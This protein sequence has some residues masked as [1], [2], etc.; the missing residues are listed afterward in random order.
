M[1]RIYLILSLVAFFT[2][3]VSFAQTLEQKGTELIFE[4]SIWFDQAINYEIK[5]RYSDDN[6]IGT[7]NVA[8]CED[9]KNDYID[10]WLNPNMIIVAKPGQVS[11]T[12]NVV[13][14]YGEGDNARYVAPK[15][16]IHDRYAFYSTFKFEA[17][18]A[19]Y[20][21]PCI[22]EYS[23]LCLPFSF[24]MEELITPGDDNMQLE[25]LSET[26]DDVLYLKRIVDLQTKTST[27]NHHHVPA[28]SPLFVHLHDF[29]PAD[30]HA[31]DEEIVEKNRM[32]IHTKGAI[33]V[34]YEEEKEF[35]DVAYL[36]EGHL[37]PTVIDANT[38]TDK[39]YIKYSEFW[40]WTDMVDENGEYVTVN[41]NQFRC[42]LN[43]FTAGNPGDAKNLSLVSV[44][45]TTAI[46]TA[47]TTNETPA[48][49]L[50]GI[51]VAPTAKG[52]V[53]KNGNKYFNK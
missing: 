36:L 8:G 16:N 23:T 53:I 35:S 38:N 11:N 32:I 13:L 41:V 15:L 18:E 14:V 37:V 34:N 27:S 29:I 20:E 12:E 10:T 28:G 24:N 5:K 47:K 2:S 33:T 1:K 4:G 6:P 30:A 49:N 52:F 7:I 44:E 31:P 43:D 51:R 42:I 48:Y 25:V 22:S 46:E 26:S 21:R 45:N 17:E 40:K 39:Y 19:Y 9:L 50:Q 3:G